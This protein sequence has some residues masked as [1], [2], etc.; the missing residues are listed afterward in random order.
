MINAKFVVISQKLVKL[1]IFHSGSAS[2]DEY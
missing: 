1:K 2:V